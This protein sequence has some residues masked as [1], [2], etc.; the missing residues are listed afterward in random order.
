M[1]ATSNST[2]SGSAIG[3]LLAAA[4]GL[5][6]CSGSAQTSSVEILHW[7]KQG[8]EAEAIHALLADFQRQNPSIKVVDSSV[9]GSSTARAVI[10]NRMSTMNPPDTFQANGG[11]DLMAW[12]LYYGTNADQ[13]K[14]QELDPV[15]LDL[16]GNVPTEVLDTVSYKGAVYAVPLNIHRLNTFFYNKAVFDMLGIDASQLNTLDDMFAAADKV[17]QYNQQIADDP[18]AR[19]IT[20]IAL[21]YRA[22]D[23]DVTTGDSWTLALVFFENILVARMGGDAYQNLFVKPGM[24]DAFMPAMSNALADLRRLVVSY[25]N[26][27]AAALTWNQPLDMVLNGTAAMTIMGDWG[28]GYANA[29]G[30]GE[31]TFGVIPTPGTAGTFVFT[32]DTFG[33]PIGALDPDNTMKLLSVFASREG[34]DIFNPI[35]G[36]IS[37]RTDS[38]IDNGQ[39][40]AMARQTFQDFKNAAVKVPATSILAP[41]SYIDAISVALAEF[42]KARDNANPSTVQHTLDDYADVLRSSCWPTCQPPQ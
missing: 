11:W 40:D 16:A 4:V 5:A 31:E 17:N 42:A 24:R 23:G 30:K 22:T 28:K 33:L 18:N 12:V 32:T 38:Q 20:P 39:Y 41:Q 27:N 7:W 3:F 34:Q 19:P 36:S 37:A 9:D 2:R 21:G 25:S 14:M 8:G 13:S 10:R 29:A 1:R 35:K 26:Q 15:A 6:A